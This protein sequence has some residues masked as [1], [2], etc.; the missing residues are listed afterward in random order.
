MATTCRFNPIHFVLPPNNCILDVNF[1]VGIIRYHC[2]LQ[3][4]AFFG[5]MPALCA[6]RL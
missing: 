3:R 6:T 1:Y 5:T 2:E 4:Q